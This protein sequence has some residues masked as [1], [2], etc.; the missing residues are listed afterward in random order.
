MVIKNFKK[1]L[2]AGVNIFSQQYCIDNTMY[3]GLLPDDICAG[4]PTTQTSNG[5]AGGI[6]T[7]QVKLIY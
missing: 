3:T 4:V 7:C 2:S 1:L 5:A 6:D